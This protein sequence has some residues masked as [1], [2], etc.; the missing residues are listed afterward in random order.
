MAGAAQKE[1]EPITAIN[2]TPLV[3][4]CLVLV[5]IFM[6][7]APMAVTLGIKVLESRASNAEGK[8]SVDENV[9]VKLALDGQITDFFEWRGA[10]MINP[11]P[12]LGAMWKAER[13][14]TAIYFG[15]DLD[16]F[17]LRLDPDEQ[18]RARQQELQLQVYIQTAAGSFRLA[19]PF[20]SP[21]EQEYIL[22]HRAADGPWEDI[23]SSRLISR[24]AIVEL[25][26]PVKDLRVEPGDSLRV[27][28]V[29]LEHGLEVGRYPHQQ[30]AIVTV[31][32]PDFDATMWRV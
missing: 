7:V 18:S 31:P 26:V 6:A 9:Q 5:I 17:F 28:V 12:P 24:K 8:A 14:F 16:R 13:L 10:G 15:W 1:D 32:G 11:N 3:D 4:V 23:D 20:A 19:W 29:A 22:A 30:P 21:G 27:S 2:V 25:A